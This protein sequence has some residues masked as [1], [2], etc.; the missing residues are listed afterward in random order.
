MLAFVNN[1]AYDN[2]KTLQVYWAGLKYTL[3]PDVDLVLAY[4]GYNQNSYATGKNAGCST[5]VSGSCSGKE[6]VASILLD[7]RLTKRF[8]VYA[9]SMWSG[10]TNGLANGYIARDNIATTLGLRFKF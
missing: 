4:Y 2:Q 9:G 8:D 3:V 5:T 1:A 6:N 7:Y 10:V